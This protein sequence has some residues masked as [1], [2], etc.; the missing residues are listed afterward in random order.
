M[1]L[2]SHQ[3]VNHQPVRAAVVSLSSIHLFECEAC[4]LFQASHSS[5]LSVLYSY[6]KCLLTSHYH[7]LLQITRKE[8]GVV[9]AAS[10]LLLK[11]HNYLL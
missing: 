9:V 3:F 8:V 4:L 11:L 1:V 5:L 6:Y 2:P 10:L 7:L